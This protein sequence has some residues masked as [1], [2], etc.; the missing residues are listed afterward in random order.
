[1]GN[2]Q[3]SDFPAP[4]AVAAECQRAFAMGIGTFV[5]R[6]VAAERQLRPGD[7]GWQIFTNDIY[8][9]L[10]EMERTATCGTSD[11]ARLWQMASVVRERG[12]GVTLYPDTG[13]APPRP[14][15]HLR[16]REIETQWA[17]RKRTRH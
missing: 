15:A 13:G 6:Y 16:P 4:S 8:G 9:F 12:A 7:D 1:M 10:C 5:L 2:V 3:G 14:W 11:L 17:P